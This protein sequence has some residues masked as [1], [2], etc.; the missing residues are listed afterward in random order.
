[1]DVYPGSA[2]WTDWDYFYNDTDPDVTAEMDLRRG[3]IPAAIFLYALI[4]LL[5]VPGN[6]AVIWIAG[7][8]MPRKPNPTWFLNL[9]V[10]DLLCCLS[11]PFLVTQLAL[12]RRWLFGWSLCKIL[13]AATIFSMFASVFVLTGISVD[14]CLMTFYPLWAHCRRTVNHVGLACSLA[15]ALALLMSLPS[16]L[17]RE[18]FTIN[19]TDY[20]TNIYHGEPALTE[21][22]IQVT[23]FFFGFLL[24][25][26]VIGACNGLIVL[27]VRG[28]RFARPGKVHRLVLLVLLG[29]FVCWLPYHVVGLLLV[30]RT[31]GAHDVHAEW[32]WGLLAV[33]PL[34]TCLAYLNSCVNPFLYAFMGRGF[35]Q[36]VRRS[37]R[38]V[39]ENAFE[40]EGSGLQAKSTAKSVELT[41]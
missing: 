39:F 5:G 3:L 1:M 16:S 29:F 21:R 20:C 25:F 23:R 28:S 6:A 14:R 35:K 8:R 38:H 12:E 15:W 40:E 2:N 31:A 30:A 11:L 34:I 13:P 36:Q 22:V 32:K 33:D 9:A 19:G 24:P 7:F 37:L 17:Y 41:A 4:F 18:I 26:L 10:A 27:K